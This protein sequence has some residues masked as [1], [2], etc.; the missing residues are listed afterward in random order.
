MSTSQAITPAP[1]SRADSFVLFVS[2][3]GIA[4]VPG[5]VAELS[6]AVVAVGSLV[7]VAWGRVVFAPGLM[8]LPL[9]LVVAVCVGA[10]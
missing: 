1:I 4:E 5:P 10:A 7:A 9:A 6:A 2:A 3:A 8:V